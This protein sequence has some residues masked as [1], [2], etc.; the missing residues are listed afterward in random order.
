IWWKEKAPLREIIKLLRDTYCGHIGADYMHLL[1][2]EERRWLRQRMESSANKANLD[3][4][5]K[6]QILHKLNQ[7]MAFEEFLHKKYIGHKRFSLEGAD[8]L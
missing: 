6:K 3:K 7:A 1:D 8:T 2:L 5:D 4:D